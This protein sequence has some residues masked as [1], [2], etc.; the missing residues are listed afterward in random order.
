MRHTP[1]SSLTVARG[2]SRAGL[3]ASTVTRGSTAFELSCTVPVMV[4]PARLTRPTRPYKENGPDSPRGSGSQTRC[5][6]EA[7]WDPHPTN[8]LDANRRLAVET[9]MPVESGREGLPSLPSRVLLK[10]DTTYYF[11]R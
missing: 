10:P 4:A 8:G 2:A 1:L 5:R 9:T 7:A 11:T 3:V 6:A